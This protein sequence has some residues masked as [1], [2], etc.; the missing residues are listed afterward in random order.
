MFYR[1][2]ICENLKKSTN[3]SETEKHQPPQFWFS[4]GRNTMDRHSAQEGDGFCVRDKG[5][6]V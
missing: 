3:V 5:V 1:N 4:S 6:L 2:E